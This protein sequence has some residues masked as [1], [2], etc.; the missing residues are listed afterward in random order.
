[1]KRWA[2]NAAVD[3]ASW[4]LGRVADVLLGKV[5]GEHVSRTSMCRNCGP[6]CLCAPRRSG[7]GW[8]L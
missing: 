6:V 1:M 7:G 5:D 4:A 2:V 3:A 8:R